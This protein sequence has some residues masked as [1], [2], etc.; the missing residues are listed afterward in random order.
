M[1]SDRLTPAP[2]Q[3]YMHMSVHQLKAFCFLACK[4]GIMALPT[5]R[6]IMRINGMICNR[7][8]IILYITKKMFKN[9]LM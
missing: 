3:P 9:H 8:K 1:G 7:M 5:L 4:R 2:I 6:V